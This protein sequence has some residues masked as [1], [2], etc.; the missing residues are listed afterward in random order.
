MRVKVFLPPPADA[1]ITSCV[2]PVAQTSVM[3]A[4]VTTLC[5]PAAAALALLG[6]ALLGVPIYA[7]VTFGDSLNAL[8]GVS[9]WWM[10]G[11]LPAF[12]YAVFAMP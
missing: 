8:A 6:C 2:N 7:V 5:F 3:A 4:I 9:L 1:C 11:F 10:I 12:A